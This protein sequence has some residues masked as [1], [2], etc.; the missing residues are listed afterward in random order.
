MDKE[1]RRTF[2]RMAAG[3]F[4]ALSCPARSTPASSSPSDD[5]TPAGQIK[6]RIIQKYG[7]IPDLP[8]H[9]T[10]L[11]SAPASALQS[12]PPSVDLRM[13]CPPIYHQDGLGS[14]TANAI[15]GALQYARKK[16]GLL[17]DFAPSRLFIYYN[18]R[19]LEGTIDKDAGAQLHDGM[20]TA[21]DLGYPPE[22]LWKYD[23]AKFAETPPP[24]VYA[25]AARHKAIQY[26]QL[27][28]TLS[29][30]KGCLASGF[31]FFFGF[32]VYPSFENPEVAQTGVV[33]MP[34][35]QETLIAGHAVLAV[36]YYESQQRFIIRNSY[37]TSWGQHGYGTMPYAYLTSPNLAADFWT[38]RL[39]S[40]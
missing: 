38:I 8:D 40:F 15:T 34:G 16:A 25:E 14:C 27:A 36:G 9:R 20:A 2:L 30:M 1:H 26:F 37:G 28:Q 3:T 7:W 32:T 4:A 18:E 17:P 13:A 10:I 22:D 29:Q 31:P 12:L 23:V 35:P 24:E 39:A 6:P 21:H 5:Q 19:A 11:Y 33:Q